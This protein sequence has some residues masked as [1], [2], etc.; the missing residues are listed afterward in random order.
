MNDE[1]EEALAGIAL[2]SEMMVLADTRRLGDEL[3]AGM[4]WQKRN[5]R[6]WIVAADERTCVATNIWAAH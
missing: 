4:S 2:L 3:P 5:H 1:H 6:W